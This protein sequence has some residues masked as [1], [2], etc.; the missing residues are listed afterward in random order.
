M[1]LDW[2]RKGCPTPA[3]HSAVVESESVCVSRRYPLLL[4]SQGVPGLK[5]MPPNSPI[6][7]RAVSIMRAVIMEPTS[8]QTTDSGS[9]GTIINFVGIS[10]GGR[11]ETSYSFWPIFNAY[12]FAS[13]AASPLFK[14]NSADNATPKQT[15]QQC[16]DNFL[17]TGYGPAGNFMAKTMVP[18]FSAISLFTNTWSWAKG[19]GIALLG[20][21][22]LSAGPMAYGKLM[23]TT[24]TNLLQYPGQAAAASDAL[25]SGAAWS[26]GGALAGEV[27]L[28]VGVE[29]S[30]F[31]TTADAYARWTCRNVP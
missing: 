2:E 21:G 18:S 22:A 23:T 15:K 24:G 20:K 13:S 17:K 10:E 4:A 5:T 6:P 26:T 31:A 29:G 25:S 28:F 16:I 19:E 11:W 8:P 30:V 14:R 3:W 12:A 9:R 7:R 1:S 27:L